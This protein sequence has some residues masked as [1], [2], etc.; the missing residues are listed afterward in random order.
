MAFRALSAAVEAAFAAKNAAIENP[1]P[2]MLATPATRVKTFMGQCLTRN[3]R[4]RNTDCVGAEVPIVRRRVRRGAYYL[5]LDARCVGE[6]EGRKGRLTRTCTVHPGAALP[7]A[8]TRISNRTP[9]VFANNRGRDPSSPRQAERGAP[10]PRRLVRTPV[11]VHLLPLGEGKHS[12]YAPPRVIGFPSPRGIGWAGEPQRGEITK[13]R[14]T[15]WV[16]GTQTDT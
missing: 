8:L 11:A 10:C 14:P 15:A 4:R 1:N 13:P 7:Y 5:A 2:N 6:R 9:P 12:F 3:T 16:N